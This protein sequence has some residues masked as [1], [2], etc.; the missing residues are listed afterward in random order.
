MKVFKYVLKP[1][2][3]QV[4]MMPKEARVLSCHVQDRDICVW[5]LVDPDARK[6]SRTFFIHGTGHEVAYPHSGTFVGTVLLNQGLLVLH[7]FVLN[8]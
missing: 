2:D 4:V 1:T 7:V 6:E 8:V 3:E 5:A